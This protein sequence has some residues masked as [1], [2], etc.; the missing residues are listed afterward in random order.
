MI[1]VE[2]RFDDYA[3]RVSTFPLD[4]TVSTL[5][6]GQWVTLKGGKLV[7]ATGTEK[8]AFIAIGSKRVGRDQVAGKIVDK[9]AVLMGNF[10]LTVSNFDSMGSYTED[11]TAL[12]IKEGGILTPT[13]GD[14]DHVVAY[15]IGKPINGFLRIVSA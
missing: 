8:K 6:E 12:K 9:V 3:Y 2:N 10:V 11:M 5:E 13:T 1:K 7:I 4:P 15:A 14:T